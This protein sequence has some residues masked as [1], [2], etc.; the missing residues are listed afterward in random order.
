VKKSVTQA[1]DLGFKVIVN[2]ASSRAVLPD[3]IDAVIAEMEEKGAVFV[4]NADDIIV[5]NFA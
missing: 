1:L 2:L 4:S 3:T 5:E